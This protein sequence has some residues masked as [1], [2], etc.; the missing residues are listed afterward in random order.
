MSSHA[1]P[2]E[3]R[4]EAFLDALTDLLP[5]YDHK[6]LRTLALDYDIPLEDAQALAEL[7]LGLDSAFPVTEMSSQFKAH[8]RTEL[9]GKPQAQGVI[10][11]LV[12]LPLRLQIA[13][14]LAIVAVLALL[15]RKR[16]AAQLR[17]LIPQLQS[18]AADDA[19]AVNVIVQ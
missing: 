4:E 1:L 12:K 18:L 19:D 2:Y 5:V 16:V 17:R 8:L 7:V 15:G 11:R 6:H 9:I 14:L 3:A 13:A 10:G